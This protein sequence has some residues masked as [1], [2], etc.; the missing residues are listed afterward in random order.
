MPTLFPQGG[1]AVVD[2]MCAKFP[3]LFVNDDEK[4]RVL[5]QRIGEQFAF[6]FG[7]QWGNK[8]RAGL[9]DAFRSKDSIAALEADG[10]VSIWDMFQGSSPVVV[11][12][13][14]GKPPD[15]PNDSPANTTFM[16]CTPFDHLGG[17]G[18]PQPEPEPDP[19][20]EARVKALEDALVVQEGIN[21]QLADTL[22]AQGERLNAL[23]GRVAHVE[24][25]FAK[26]WKVRGKTASS[27]YHQHGVDLTVTRE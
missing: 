10:T 26:V 22:N 13:S 12:V 6:T 21:Q 23:E 11:L 27:V 9:S 3:E 20:L 2:A 4:Q 15:F 19:A 18:G 16:P 25:E 1:R 7:T 24:A 8:K 5:T 17:G 14:D